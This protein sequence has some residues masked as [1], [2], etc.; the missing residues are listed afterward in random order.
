MLNMTPGVQIS[1]TKRFSP[2]RRTGR[3]WEVTWVEWTL[4]RS[5]NK[6]DKP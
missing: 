4:E 6:L 2:H 1:A 3:I 5:S